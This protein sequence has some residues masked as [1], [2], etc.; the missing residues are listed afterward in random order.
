[1][2]KHQLI[3]ARLKISNEELVHGKEYLMNSIKES[4]IEQL[5]REL[6]EN[7]Q[8][9][10]T[11]KESPDFANMATQFRL[12]LICISEYDYRKLEQ[13]VGH[14]NIANSDGEIIPLKE[15]L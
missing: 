13:S 11:I 6:L 2:K 5:I 9:L 4:L 8:D 3:R 7:H 12:N 14:L 1:M 15:F 10:L